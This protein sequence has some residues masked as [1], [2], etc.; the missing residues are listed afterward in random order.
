[1]GS[2][3]KYKVSCANKTM[4]NLRS[5]V[6]LTGV[7]FNGYVMHK[8]LIFIWCDINRFP[9]KIGMSRSY[10][11][12]GPPPISSHCAVS[13]EHMPGETVPYPCHFQAHLVV[14]WTCKEFDVISRTRSVWLG[15]YHWQRASPI[16]L[17]GQLSSYLVEKLEWSSECC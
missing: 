5:E 15:Q 4:I 9:F 7:H 2:L 12:T 14:C 17:E 16:C 3:P 1:M 10:A 13:I 8:L 11:V 6:P